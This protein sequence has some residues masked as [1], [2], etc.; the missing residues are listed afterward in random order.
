MI[1]SDPTRERI[2]KLMSLSL[3]EFQTTLSA[4]IGRPVADDESEITHELGTASVTIAYTP[5]PSVTFGGLLH[6]PRALVSL[7]FVDATEGDR[8]TFLT[9]FDNHFRRGGG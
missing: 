6:M 1:T 2:E 4:L 5:Q 3:R 7:T 8:S 9:K